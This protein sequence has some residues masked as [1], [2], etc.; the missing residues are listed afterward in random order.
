M[1]VLSLPRACYS[2][3]QIVGKI[4]QAQVKERR[5]RRDVLCKSYTMRIRVLIPFPVCFDLFGDKVRLEPERPTRVESFEW[6]KG[7][8]CM[9]VSP[10]PDY[11][12][13]DLSICSLGCS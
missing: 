5:G 4:A 3:G 9:Y 13:C 6:M 1:Q 12:G 11:V 10:F 7:L 2:N 8:Y